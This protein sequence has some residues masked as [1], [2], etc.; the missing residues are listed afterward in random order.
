MDDVRPFG[1]RSDVLIWELIAAA[2]LEVDGGN[3]GR[4]IGNPYILTHGFHRFS[5]EWLELSHTN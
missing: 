4:V 3:N 2:R 1:L 5:R